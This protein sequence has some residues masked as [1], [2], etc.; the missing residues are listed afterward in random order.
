[1]NASEYAAKMALLGDDNAIMEG[2]VPVW[3]I[4][5]IDKYS[6]AEI[7]RFLDDTTGKID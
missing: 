6:K 5:V 4:N 2:T 3:V 7:Q 1:M